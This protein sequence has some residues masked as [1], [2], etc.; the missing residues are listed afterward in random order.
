MNAIHESVQPKW[1]LDA[2]TVYG[3]LPTPFRLHADPRYSGKGVTIA[4]VDSGFYPHP[5]LTQPCNRIAAWVDTSQAAPQVRYFG[6]DETPAWPGWNAVADTQW[7]GTMTTCVAAGN[8]WLSQG[9][10]RG[11]ACDARLVLL[12]VKDT[13]GRISN[14]SIARALGWLVEN[15]VGLGIRVVNI[16]LGGEPVSSLKGNPVD[17]AVANLIAQGITVVVAAGNDGERKLVPPATAPDALTIGGLDDKNT[18]DQDEMRLWHSNYGRSDDDSPKPELVA[19]SIWVVAPILPLTP[20]AQEAKALFLRRAAGDSSGEARI[21]ELKLVSAY[22]QH[23]DGTSFAAPLVA[24]A[25]AC[26]LEANPAL[27]P[28][29]VRDA[30][31]ETAH[32]VPQ[33]AP[34]RQGTGTLEAGRAVALALCWRHGRPLWHGP[35]VD[36]SGIFYEFHDD[37]AQTLELYGSWDGWQK[38]LPASQIS[39]GVWLAE[40][41]L[42]PPGRY[43]YKARMDGT[44]WLDDPANPKK[45]PDGFGGLNSVLVVPS[46]GAH[47][48]QVI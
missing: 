1:P 43:V 21:A 2:E 25:V 36:K 17:R 8:G 13:A 6:P 46:S 38:A 9:L 12:K 33:A 44:R 27:T 19:P 31:M 41:P 48:A 24:S 4:V 10:Y 34:E 42:L 11:L 47:S 20:L 18:Y 35:R 45:E 7:H 39:A 23:V 29:L 15:G 14:A 30:L 28:D 26:L 16:S 40:Q 5:D 37:Q 22:Y 32:W 3:A